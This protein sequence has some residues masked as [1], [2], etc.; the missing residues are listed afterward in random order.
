LVDLFEK[1]RAFVWSKSS[2]S[3][4]QE[5]KK[6]KKWTSTKRFLRKD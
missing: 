6:L 3:R 4:K 5:E 2:I 1:G